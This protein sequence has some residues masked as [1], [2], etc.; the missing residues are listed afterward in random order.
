MNNFSLCREIITVC[1]D[2]HTQHIHALCGQNVELSNVK[3]G[4]TAIFYKYMVV[5]FL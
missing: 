1:T 5:P 3:P 2:I 4:G